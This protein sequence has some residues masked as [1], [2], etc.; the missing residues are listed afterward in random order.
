MPLS[1]A[2]PPPFLAPRSSVYSGTGVKIPTVKIQF[3]L[4][5]SVLS[6]DPLGGSHG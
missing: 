3:I 5:G 4:F 1:L 2:C 6:L